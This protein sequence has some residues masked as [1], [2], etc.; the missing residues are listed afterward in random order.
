L[1]RHHPIDSFK[2]ISDR[3]RRFARLEARGRSPLYEEITLAVAGDAWVLRFLSSLP[4]AKQQ[5]NLLLAAV[6]HVCGTASGWPEFRAWLEQEN[7]RIAEVMRTRRTQT[8][9]PARCS[10]LLPAVAQLPQPLALI[11]VGAAAG[12]CLLPDYYA[13]HYGDKFVPCGVRIGVDTPEFSCAVSASTPVPSRNVEVAWRAGLDLEPIDVH[14][15]AQV[16]WLETLVWPGE[17]R[18]LELLREAIEIARQ[19]KPTIHKGN[20]TTHLSELLDQAPGDVTLVVFH[21]AVL[22]YLTPDERAAFTMIARHRAIT[23]VANEGA[24]LQPHAMTL[25]A[26]PVRDDAFLLTVNEKPVAWTDPHG[27]SIE[28]IEVASSE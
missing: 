13:Y 28:W 19:V 14:D 27:T 3:Y 10:T 8:N 17:G 6:R 22:P 25:L 20:L 24:G 16:E 23:W 21:S 5:P 12:L 2:P 9:E 1:K 7:D 26:Q 18:R 11:E 4:R 15:R